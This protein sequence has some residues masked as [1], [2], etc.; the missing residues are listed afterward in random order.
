MH[1]IDN[2]FTRVLSRDER[3][4]VVPFSKDINIQ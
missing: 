2:I 4:H 1:N 3:E